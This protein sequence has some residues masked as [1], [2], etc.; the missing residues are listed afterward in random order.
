MDPEK[1]VNPRFIPTLTE[2]V[3]PEA[4]A[5][6]AVSQA[7]DPRVAQ[8]V[9]QLVQQVRQSVNQ[10]SQEEFRSLAVALADRLWE[11]ASQNF[12]DQLRQ[13]LSPIVSKA[14]R[15]GMGQEKL[16]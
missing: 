10:A 2:V 1:S 5:M 8:L 3:S 11:A 12:E 6:E 9:D 15:Q 14:I 13:R 7:Q 16:G 4:A